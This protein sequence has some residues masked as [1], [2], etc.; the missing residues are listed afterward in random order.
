MSAALEM[1]APAQSRRTTPQ[2]ELDEA[3]AVLKDK[4]RTFAR[5]GPSVKASLI[6]ETMACLEKV[7]AE[8]VADG[9]RAKQI[10]T[11]GPL[12]GEEWL[13][14]PMVTMRNLRL[15]ARSLDDIAQRGKPHLDDKQLRR[16]G[17]GRTEVR[18]FPSDAIDGAMFS[19]FTAYELMLPGIGA[20]EVR[21]RQASFYGKKDPEGAVSL[22][23][24]AGNVSSIPPMDFLYKA[25]A[26]GSVALIK[27]N[28]VNEWVGA[29]LERGFKPFIDAGYLRIV[30]GGGDVGAYLC[31]AEAVSDVH[32][33]GS[34]HTHDLIVWGPPGPERERRKAA[35][36]PVLKK[37][38]TSEL[39][40]VSPIA[41]VPAAYSDGE[42]E[43][44][45]R[46]I[47][48]MVT[49]NGSF[50]C[51]AGKLLVTSAAWP[52]RSALLDRMARLFETI[53]TRYA[54]YPGA[55]DRYRKLTEG[56]D[57]KKIGRP[58]PDHLPWTMVLNV[59][60]KKAEEPVFATEPFCAIVSETTIEAKEPA[61]FIDAAT[62][63]MNER[64]WGT[65]NAMFIIHPKHEHSAEVGGRLERAIVDLQYGTVAINHWP[66]LAYGFVSSAWGG[67]PTSTLDDIQSGLGWVHNTYLLEGIE[68]TVVRGPLTMF[69]K[70]AW[71]FDNRKVD[72]I[73]RKL[74]ELE[75][76]PGWLKV[77]GVAIAALGG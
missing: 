7:G 49:N 70:P 48:S 15:L 26:E 39:G 33:T 32:I 40:N 76:A 77:P 43:F 51:N 36:D 21:A 64:L 38:I 17:D 44:I 69:P 9:C 24:G 45:A 23:L 18:V 12:S 57:V 68:K 28:P 19:G 67:H 71:F 35:N 63:F 41:V 22:I 8:W 13:A 72:V 10:P 20:D 3:L 58:G 4:A 59:D 75:R 16:R 1:S 27:M 53:P 74:F 42:L 56:R 65:L 30:Y 66:A 34:N 54:Y 52:Q 31:Q 2:K 5:L 29:H 25:I 47:V 14:G 50:N 60:S 61:E 6:R 55:H 73:G 37:T 62:Q 46:N 11:E